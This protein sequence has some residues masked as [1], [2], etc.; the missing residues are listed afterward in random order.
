M[1]TSDLSYLNTKFSRVFSLTSFFYTKLTGINGYKY[2]SVEHWTKRIEIFKKDIILIPINIKGSHWILAAVFMKEQFRIS[3]LDSLGLVT[4]E[5]A[6]IIGENL[7]YFHK[8]MLCKGDAC[9]KYKVRIE[10]FDSKVINRGKFI[11]R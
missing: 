8:I 6:V 3:I 4:T 10:K 7:E 9:V 5:E 11:F 2:S 1:P